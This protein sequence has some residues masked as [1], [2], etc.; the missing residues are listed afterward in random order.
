MN[1]LNL[2]FEA[3][4]VSFGGDSIDAYRVIRNVPAQSMLTGL[5]ANALGWTR[6]MRQE[7]DDLQR[8]IRF[9]MAWD[10]LPGP[11]IFVDYQTAKLSGRTKV[12]TTRGVP[13][14]RAGGAATYHGSHQKWVQYHADARI[15]LVLTV[16]DPGGAPALEQ[17]AT[18]LQ[19]PARPLFLGRKACPPAS[20]IFR[21]MLEGPKDAVSALK[22]ALPNDARDKLA[23][24]PES[25]GSHD[26]HR[27][28]KV[29]DY[30]NWRTRLHGGI[31]SICEGR[32]SASGEDG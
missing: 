16:K 8:R 9:A 20:P 6:T 32:V 22:V 23:Y 14:G 31:R 11:R 2:R 28:I 21:G 17:I 13:V 27:R 4:M 15:A 10:S 3:P 1:W 12:W 5:L 30:R 24:W 25:E 7:H 29:A 19:R 26:C 18:A